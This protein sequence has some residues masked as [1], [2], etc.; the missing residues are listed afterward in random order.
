M[1]YR[2]ISSLCVT[3]FILLLSNCN[4]SNPKSEISF[5][6]DIAPIIHANCTPCHRPGEAGPFSLIS[7]QDVKK[8]AKMVAYVTKIKYMPPWPADPSYSHFIGE[9]HLEQHEIDLIQEWFQAG[10]PEGVEHPYP[11]PPTFAKGSQL[12]EP[13]LVIEVPDS[14]LIPGD[15]TDRFLLVKAPFEIPEP[16]LVKAV[17]FV[18]GNRTLV[19]HMNGHVV[20]FEYDKKANV[21][22][23]RTWIDPET[24]TVN[25]SNQMLGLLNDDGS[26]PVLTPLVCS[27]LPSVTPPIYPKGIGGFR[28]NRKGAFYVAN[29]HYGPSPIDAYD[30]SKFNVFFTDEPIER[31][32]F[33][34]QM[35]TLGISEVVPPLV[36]PPDTVMK[37]HTK[38]RIFNDIS[39]LTLNPH[40]HLIGTSF[41]AYAVSPSNDTIPLIKIPKW[42]FR[43]QYF[44]TFP[45]MVKIPAGSMIYA[46]GW[47]DNT[48]Q[49]I[50]NPFT[51]SQTVREPEG[52]M[53]TT[54]EMFQFIFNYLPYQEGDENISLE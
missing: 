17:E 51:P 28:M 24:Q 22:E 19:H 50:N 54:D 39:I 53:K 43:W 42:D 36:I 12:G 45:K 7:Y 41:L 49:N 37:F 40:M 32:L 30:K 46:E 20:N 25:E 47:F 35:G 15:N 3:A 6:K 13:D 18:P 52:D 48:Q 33:E 26:Y 8:R 11:E 34:T 14:I 9:K 5:N 38:I 44:Y 29:M 16:R 27:Y 4:N 21:F 31:P 2:V 23:G 1:F 10:A